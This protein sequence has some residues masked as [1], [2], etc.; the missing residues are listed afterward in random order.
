MGADLDK[1]RA[2]RAAGR[3]VSPSA[4]IPYE[5]W[6]RVVVGHVVARVGSSTL[7]VGPCILCSLCSG[8]A[9]APEI[10]FFAACSVVPI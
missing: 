10:L 8:V 6:R 3:Q 7:V 2:G 5:D 9:L 1:T 4:E